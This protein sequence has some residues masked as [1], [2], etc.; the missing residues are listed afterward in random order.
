MGGGAIH[1]WRV[2][3]PVLTQ[4]GTYMYLDICCIEGGV[5]IVE[6]CGCI[7]SGVAV[8]LQV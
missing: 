8:V 5:M 7:F 2:W 3:N 6:V 4:S 1:L